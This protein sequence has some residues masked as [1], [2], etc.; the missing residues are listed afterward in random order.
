MLIGLLMAGLVTSPTPTPSPA[1]SAAVAST[2]SPDYIE[3]R[4]AGI[5]A[6]ALCG[7][8]AAAFLVAVKV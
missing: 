5:E 8:F 7:V 6:A 3:A 2:V 4:D 1:V